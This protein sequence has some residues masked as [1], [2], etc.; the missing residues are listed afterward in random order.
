MAGDELTPQDHLRAVLAHVG[1]DQDPECAATPDAFL[2]LLQGLDPRRPPPE[3]TVLEASSRDPLLLRDVPF[4]SLCAHHLVPVLGSACVAIRPAGRLVGL[5]SIVRLL[6][7]HALRPQLQ[8]RLGAQLADDL[9]LRLGARSAVVHLR[10]RHL[11]ME[12]RGVKT[13]AWVETLAWRGEE[14]PELRMML[15]DAVVDGG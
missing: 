7:H 9:M 1:F 10:G 11:C 12:M 6:Q 8:E 5:G 2:E 13:P 4:H 14:D 3:I 15:G